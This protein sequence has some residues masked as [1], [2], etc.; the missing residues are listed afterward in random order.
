MKKLFGVVEAIF[1]HGLMDN[2]DF[3]LNLSRIV[4]EPRVTDYKIP[5]FV[6]MFPVSKHFEAIKVGFT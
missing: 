3:W 5:E 6:W 1:V 2:V 4:I